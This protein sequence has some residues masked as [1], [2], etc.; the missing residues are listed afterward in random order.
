MTTDVTVKTIGGK[1]VTV[2]RNRKGDFIIY[3]SDK[4]TIRY[5]DDQVKI[6][7]FTQGGRLKLGHFSLLRA[8]ED[9][10]E[11]TRK[12]ET[13]ETRLEDPILYAGTITWRHDGKALFYNNDCGRYQPD[14]EDTVYLAKM[15]PEFNMDMETAE[16][17]QV[18]N[19]KNFIDRIT[20]YQE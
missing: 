18:T 17:K 2:H 12:S 4:T 15:N 8:P 11:V 3:T 20:A 1:S 16:K 6:D 9:Y 10:L 5:L 19:L 7:Y 13:N 14:K